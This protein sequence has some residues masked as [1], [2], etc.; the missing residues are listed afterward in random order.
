MNETQDIIKYINQALEN[1]P[2]LNLHQYSIKVSLE[3]DAVVIEGEVDNIAA[4]KLALDI[5]NHGSQTRNY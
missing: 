2:C 4:K 3:R 5:A 1:E